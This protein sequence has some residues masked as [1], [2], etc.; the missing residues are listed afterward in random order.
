MTSLDIN[1]S[2]KAQST[3][4]T[5][6]ILAYA[7]GNMNPENVENGRFGIVI[8]IVI[9]KVLYPLFVNLLYYS[10]YFFNCCPGAKLLASPGDLANSPGAMF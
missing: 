3:Q 2:E 5:V 8:G 1:V 9:A 7:T 10:N 4:Y 6:P